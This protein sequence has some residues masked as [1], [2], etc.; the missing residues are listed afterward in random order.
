MRDLYP[1]CRALL[2]P[3]EEDFGIMPVEAQA[4]GAPVIARAVGGAL[5]TV[6]AGTTGVLYADD[7]YRSVET[8]AAVLRDFADDDFDRSAVPHPRGAVRRPAGSGRG[9]RRS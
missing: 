5:D 4:C 9:S 2:F 8:L 6:V 7:R 3:G 1:D